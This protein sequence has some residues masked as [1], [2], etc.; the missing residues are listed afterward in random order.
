MT[1]RWV[2]FT[3]VLADDIRQ[4]L[5]HKRALG[6]RFVVE[7]AVLRLFDRYLVEQHIAVP[8]AITPA[9]VDAFLASRPRGRPRSYNHLLGTLARFFDWSVAHGYVSGSPVQAPRRRVTGQ[10]VPFIFDQ[11]SA[12][13]LLDI[14]KALKDNGRAPSRGDTYYTIFALLYGLGLRVGEVS[15]LTIADVDLARRLLIIRETKF[16]KSRLV[17]FGPKIAG[18]VAAYRA[19]CD[20]RRGPLGPGTPFFSFT[21]R[22]AIHPCTITQTFHHL[23]PRLRL[24]IPEGVASPRLH[25]L[26]H[27]FAVGTLLRWYRTG[28]DPQA[29]LLQLS[30]FLGHVDPTSTA[31]YLTI[32]PAL[33]A[34]ASERFARYAAPQAAGE[35]R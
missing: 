20:A 21:R 7:E 3:S 11:T 12:R 8:D 19:G 16:G 17:P 5:A 28:A 18:V 10:R 24:V 26:R 35:S 14:A 13:R 4:F 2:A 27:S 23:V 30:T 29:H 32:T 25:D 34:E 33:L 1:R 22:G 6:R 31:V 15:R 9:V